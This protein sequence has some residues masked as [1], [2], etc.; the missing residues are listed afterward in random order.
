MTGNECK[1]IILDIKDQK[2][3]AVLPSGNLDI[4]P[5]F[6]MSNS[7]FAEFEQEKHN[8]NPYELKWQ[9]EGYHF[10]ITLKI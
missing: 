1:K 4:D 8:D 7:K 3:T 2:L 10:P 6:Y 9:I 5:T